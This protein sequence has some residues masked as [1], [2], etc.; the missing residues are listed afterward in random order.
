MVTIFIR[1]SLFKKMSDTTISSF[2]SK[3]QTIDDEDR[4]DSAGCCLNIF[5]GIFLLITVITAILLIYFLHEFD[6]RDR[7]RERKKNEFKRKH[8]ISNKILDLIM[9]DGFVYKWIKSH[10]GPIANTFQELFKD[11]AHT[12]FNE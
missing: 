9:K 3:H 10:K 2:Y 8:R 1:S 5:S 4:S 6:K 12:I 11:I 7:E